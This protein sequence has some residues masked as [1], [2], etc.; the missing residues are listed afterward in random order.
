MGF[1]LIFSGKSLM[2][3]LSCQVDFY[4]KKANDIPNSI[5]LFLNIIVG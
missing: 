2:F 3:L 4:S 5:G 1:L